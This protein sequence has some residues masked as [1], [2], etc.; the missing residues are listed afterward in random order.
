MEFKFAISYHNHIIFT[1]IIKYLYSFDAISSN[2]R[3]NSQF[4]FILVFPKLFNV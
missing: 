1:L 3:K 4:D 2:E